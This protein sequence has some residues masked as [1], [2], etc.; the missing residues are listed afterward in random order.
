VWGALNAVYFLPLLFAKK[1]RANLDIVAKG[2]YLP[3]LKD[4]YNI[5]LTFFLTVMA[6]VLFRA[7]NLEHA[8][9]IFSKIFSSTLFSVPNFVLMQEALKVAFLVLIF[10]IIEWLQRDKQHAL[11]WENWKVSPYFKWAFIFILTEFIVV[12][13]NSSESQQFIYFNF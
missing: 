13:L 12:K 9:Y 5:L 11:E 6:W 1:N 8:F 3:S 7:E 2:K 4:S 10:L